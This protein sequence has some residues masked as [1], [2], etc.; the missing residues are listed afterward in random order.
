[1]MDFHSKRSRGFGFVTFAS[2]AA[3]KNMMRLDSHAVI[4][5]K[6]VEVKPAVPREQLQGESSWSRRRTLDMHEHAVPTR[7]ALPYPYGAGLFEPSSVLPY[8]APAD[9]DAQQALQ[10]HLSLGM[11][12]QP[13]AD[14]PGY[15]MG[16]TGL[17]EP[18]VAEDPAQWS[19][20]HS[21]M[22]PS[23]LRAPGPGSVPAY[24]APLDRSAAVLPS[25][26]MAQPSGLLA[27]GAGAGLTA[28]LG[29]GGIAL[30]QLGMQGPQRVLPGKAD[31]NQADPFEA[32]ASSFGAIS[33]Q[34]P[35]E[36]W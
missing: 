20:V 13:S 28:Q 7:S 26:G 12:Q 30:G 10:Q 16:Q 24:Q 3:A 21:R 6:T 27:P 4:C 36:H 32:F 18:T 9:R 17:S 8:Y 34:G 14:W 11:L 15:M 5:G 35:P 23:Y 22:G 2:D 31:R 29:T 25:P 19:D 1:M 33:M